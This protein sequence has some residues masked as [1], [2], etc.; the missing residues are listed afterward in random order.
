MQELYLQAKPIV[1]KLNH[2]LD[3]SNRNINVPAITGKARGEKVSFSASGIG[4]Q[5][6]FA[7]YAVNNI[8]RDDLPSDYQFTVR[9]NMKITSIY[10]PNGSLNSDGSKICCCIR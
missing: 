3:D 5:Y 8:V 4:E 2:F 9:S 7:F 10:H 1:L 6:S